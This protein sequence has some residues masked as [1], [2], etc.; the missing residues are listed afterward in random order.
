MKI[1]AVGIGVAVIICVVVG[2][3]ILL[4]LTEKRD[5]SI[6]DEIEKAFDSYQKQQSKMEQVKK[7]ITNKTKTKTK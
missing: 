6:P 4:K 1:I 5:T 2:Y 7:K 3:E